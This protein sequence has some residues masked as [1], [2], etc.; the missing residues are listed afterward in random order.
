MPMTMLTRSTTLT[1]QTLPAFCTDPDRPAASA[2]GWARNQSVD[3]GDQNQ[4]LM[5][6]ISLALLG[7]RSQCHGRRRA[8]F[9]PFSTLNLCTNFPLLEIAC[10][11]EM[12][13]ARCCSARCALSQR[14][15]N[16]G[17]LTRS[18]RYGSGQ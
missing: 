12:R 7:C 3:Q 11:G 5:G 10:A 9:K 15:L 8:G 2:A 17:S 1:E 13:S 18:A 4:P 6:I 16:V 14:D